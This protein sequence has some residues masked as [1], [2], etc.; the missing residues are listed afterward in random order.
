M[1]IVR[2]DTYKRGSWL[3]I[4]DQDGQKRRIEDC[5]MQWDGL[6]VGKEEFDPKHQQLQ[7]RPR[8]DRPARSPVRN[9]EPSNLVLEP[10]T[11]SDIV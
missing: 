11:N 7:L 4:S 6:L 5:K 10:F 3:V 9:T 1:G 8:V 2:R